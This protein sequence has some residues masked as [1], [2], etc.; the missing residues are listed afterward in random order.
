[1]IQTLLAS[2]AQRTNLHTAIVPASHSGDQPPLVHREARGRLC[3]SSVRSCAL[4]PTNCRRLAFQLG[5]GLTG[6]T[7]LD[8]LTSTR[9][10]HW[11]MRVPNE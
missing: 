7:Q 6:I 5:C 4:D 10:A 2:G 3:A 11:S 1:M 9:D 8:L